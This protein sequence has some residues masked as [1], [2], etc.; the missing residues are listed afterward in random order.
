MPSADLV[1]DDQRLCLIGRVLTGSV[2]HFPS[3]RNTLVDLWHPL[4]ETKISAKR[5]ERVKMKCGFINDIDVG[6]YRSWRGLFLGWKRD[7]TIQLR[8]I[9]HSHIDMELQEEDRRTSWRF[10]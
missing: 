6:A 9:S 5:M 4:G 2:V 8:N 10:T 3:M 7:C 1:E